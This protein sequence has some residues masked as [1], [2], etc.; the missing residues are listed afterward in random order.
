DVVAVAPA[1]EKPARWAAV[2]AEERAAVVEALR[3][4][5]HPHAETIGAIHA[6]L[7]NR[8]WLGLFSRAAACRVVAQWP[9]I[10]ELPLTI[11]ATVS[12]ASSVSSSL[13]SDESAATL[14]CTSDDALAASSYDQLDA[15]LGDY[16]EDGGDPLS[17]VE[18]WAASGY[19]CGSSV[20]SETTLV[21]GSDA[22]ARVPDS[23]ATADARPAVMADEMGIC[24]P[25][26]GAASDAACS[27][28]RF[29]AE[30]G[31]V[32]VPTRFR[33]PQH[34]LSKL[35]TEQLMMR[36][37]KIICPLKNRLQEANPR[38]QDFE[39]HIR[40]TGTIPMPAARHRSP[41]RR[42]T[43]IGAP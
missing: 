25:V 19:W 14:A 37:D 20:C 38:R 30:L 15:G 9:D 3:E 42:V 33:V 7:E 12:A 18:P 43:R 8:V 13:E 22:A 27:W 5:Q 35:A 29:Y 11:T 21:G 31:E 6:L 4:L 34:S 28:G 39:D 41:L 2:L 23:A 10:L 40:A 16:D 36:N 24:W 1:S 32:R 26:G 17:L